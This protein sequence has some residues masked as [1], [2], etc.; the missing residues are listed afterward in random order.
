M[1]LLFDNFYFC[2]K[3]KGALSLSCGSKFNNPSTEI[4]VTTNDDTKHNLIDWAGLESGRSFAIDLNLEYY[5]S[6]HPIYYGAA[7]DLDVGD[8]T[9]G[10]TGFK[11]GYYNRYINLFCKAGISS[12]VAEMD[13]SKEV[14]YS[15]HKIDSISFE[16]YG[17]NLGLGLDIH[18]GMS[19][20]FIRLS[21]DYE[22]YKPDLEIKTS[23]FTER[24]KS[25]DII[26]S[27]GFSNSSFTIAI[28]YQF[29]RKNIVAY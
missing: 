17:Y 5:C 11:I 22:N 6:N 16:G 18:P 23:G 25:Y 9:T 2:G 20:I 3:P 28:G 29:R 4:Q 8:V 13:A 1:F 27:S 10:C 26:G 12:L 24:I 15:Y 19:P 14:E 7:I 21:Y